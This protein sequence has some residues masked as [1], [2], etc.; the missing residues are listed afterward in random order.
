MKPEQSLTQ[1]SLRS[2]NH[3]RIILAITAKDILDALKNKNT[4]TSLI[5]VLFLVVM[6]KFLPVLSQD[7]I[8]FVFLYDTGHS[9]YTQALEDSD[10]MIVRVYETYEIFEERFRGHADAE[11]GLVLPADFDQVLAAA[12]VPQIQGYVLHWVSPEKV[13]QQ[14]ADL[15][16]R[17]A[18]IV[19]SP[20]RITMNGGTLTMLPDST[21][22]FLAATGMVI[23]LIVL[24][25]VLI[26]NLMLE[27]KTTRT[28]D[29]LLVSPA[30]SLQ[31]VLGK[32]FA[33]LFYSLVFI[34]LAFILN[35]SFVLQW[36]LALLTALLCTL[37]S[38]ALGLVLGT[39]I[40][41]RQQLLVVANL[42]MFPLLLPVFLSIM[43][44]LLPAWLIALMRWLPPVAASELFRISFSDQAIPLQILP[45]LGLLLV[46]VISLLGWEAWLVRRS[47][48]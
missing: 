39:T 16:N 28:M 15:E 1:K 2:R 9:V 11:L 21:G 7:E 29:A 22:G 38:V 3:F 26:P 4:L 17:I 43:T 32:A 19:G 46:A 48:R 13:E 23:I 30:N 12:K 33:G 44:D 37:I 20:V 8:P 14:R 10:T 34:L 45:R 18:G 41:N 47:D 31:I 5:S 24:G 27:E 40:D 6:Y 36:W 42:I 35:G 25:M